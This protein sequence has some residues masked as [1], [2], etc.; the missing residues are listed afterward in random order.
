MK[1][2]L[3]DILGFVLVNSLVF[4]LV[5]ELGFILIDALVWYL[6]R[7]FVCVPVGQ[8]FKHVNKP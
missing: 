1:N 4:V 5:D 8:K 2:V 3:L 7:Y 6:S